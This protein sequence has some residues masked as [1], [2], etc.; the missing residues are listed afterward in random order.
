MFTKSKFHFNFTFD[1]LEKS[2]LVLHSH[3]HP[4]DLDP[5]RVR[6]LVQRLLHDVADGLALGQDLGQVLGAQHV[7]Q[8]RRSQQVGRVAGIF[9]GWVGGRPPPGEGRKKR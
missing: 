6:G 5:P 8:R 4:L 9:G 7:A 1:I 2:K 3:L